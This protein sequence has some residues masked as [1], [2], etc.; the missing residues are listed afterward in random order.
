MRD[1]SFASSGFVD[2][3]GMEDVAWS[4][5]SLKNFFLLLGSST[6]GA[7]A[8]GVDSKETSLGLATFFLDGDIL[9]SKW[10]KIDSGLYDLLEII[11]KLEPGKLKT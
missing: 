11:L 5:S 3:S 1:G 10:G 2:N 9:K 7:T 4:S 8:C 6:L